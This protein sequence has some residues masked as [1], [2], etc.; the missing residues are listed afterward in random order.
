MHSDSM[1]IKGYSHNVCED[2]ALSA[3]LAAIVCDGCSGAVYSDVGARMLAF[4]VLKAIERFR[5]FENKTCLGALVS[6]IYPQYIKELLEVNTT[7]GDATYVAAFVDQDKVNIVARGDGA[8]FIKYKSGNCELID[9]QSI[10]NTPYYASYDLMPER[11]KLFIEAVGDQGSIVTDIR[12]NSD[13]SLVDKSILSSK[14]DLSFE[15]TI[16]LLDLSH[17]TVMSDGVSSFSKA[18]SALEIS[19]VI[20][21]LAGYKNYAGEFVKRRFNGFE[22]HCKAE[23]W[24]H[25]DDVSAAALYLG[26]D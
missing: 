21:E 19:D 17:V 18:G 26:A 14:P 11:K 9:I 7:I 1:F 22:R 20:K 25:Y 24:V 2:Y 15:L 5:C 23:G 13:F 6:A 10:N 4:T 8:V 3:N 12:L 16:P